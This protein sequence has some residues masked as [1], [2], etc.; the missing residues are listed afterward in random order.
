MKTGTPLAAMRERV[1]L[2]EARKNIA[3]SEY[4]DS[5]LPVID[6]VLGEPEKLWRVY[7]AVQMAHVVS[8]FNLDRILKKSAGFD[9]AELVDRARIDHALRSLSESG[10]SVDEIAEL[11]WPPRTRAQQLKELNANVSVVDNKLSSRENLN[12]AFTRTLDQNLDSVV[13]SLRP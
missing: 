1:G 11:Y 8:A 6:A 10:D 2:D 9:F 7:D 13:A 5:L 4:S 12:E 3:E